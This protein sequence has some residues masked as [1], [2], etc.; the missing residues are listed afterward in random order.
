MSL[1]DK[2][3][4]SAGNRTYTTLTHP[5][6]GEAKIRSL[7]E[8]EWQVGF[9][10]WFQDDTGKRIPER[11]V[12]GNVKLVQMCLIDPETDQQVYT[13]ST[14][15]LNELVDLQKE[16]T[17]PLHDAAWKHNRPGESKNGWSPKDMT[18]S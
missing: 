10:T 15:D 5:E 8:R 13:D 11:E 1:R 18:P 17:D 16:V 3:K 14:E 7:T 4:K 9:A 2:L 12:F 6:F